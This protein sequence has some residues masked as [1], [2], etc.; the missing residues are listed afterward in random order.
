MKLKL[1][2]IGNSYGVLIPKRVLPYD[3]IKSGYVELVIT[4]GYELEDNVIT[5]PKNKED[6]ITYERE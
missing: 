1:R 3:V 6:V 2:R 4:S 5:S